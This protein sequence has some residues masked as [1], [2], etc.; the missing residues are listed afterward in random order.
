LLDSALV[1]LDARKADRARER[2]GRSDPAHGDRARGDDR[3]GDPDHDPVPSPGARERGVPEGRP[4][5]AL[6]RGAAPRPHRPGREVTGARVRVALA[7]PAP[8]ARPAASGAAAIDVLRATTT[9]A[10]ARAH[11]AARI[12]PFAETTAAIA[13]RDAHPGTLAC[14]ERD[15]RIV[16]GFDLGNSPAEFT[17][18][19]VMG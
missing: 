12:V 14:G 4:V 11:G 3:G 13:Y 1:R 5:H 18:E 16:P 19:R 7:P 10:W 6:R 15:G 2:P 8:G 17:R 9:L